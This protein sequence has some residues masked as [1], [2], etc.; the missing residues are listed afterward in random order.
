MDGVSAPVRDGRGALSGTTSLDSG[1]AAVLAEELSSSS[2]SSTSRASFDA[3]SSSPTAS[4]NG[5]NNLLHF[6][7]D[8]S[9][10]L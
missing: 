5:E 3:P 1:A 9:G 6:H 2:F 8:S 4:Y 7:G 10:S